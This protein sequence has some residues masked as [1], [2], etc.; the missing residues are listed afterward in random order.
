MNVLFLAPSLGLGG[1]EKQLVV[2]ADMLQ[3]DLGLRVSAACLDQ[4][5]TQRLAVLK[6]LGVPV[7]IAGTDRSIA[8]RIGQVVS[9]ARENKAQIVHAFS[10]YLA[11]LAIVTAMAV[12]ATPAASFQGDGVADLD[13]G[14]MRRV[15]GLHLVEFFTS[16]SHEAI[17]RI[18][19]HLP[20]DAFLQYVPNLVTQ[21]AVAVQR[22]ADD[23]PAIIALVVARLD[24]NKRVDVF[25]EAL[26]RARQVEPRLRGV[27]VGDGPER[28]RLES[29]A[30]QH[31]L[32]GSG[33]EFLGLLPDPSSCYAV[34][35]IFVHLARSEGT[36]NVVLEAMAAGLPVVVT[37][38]GE[39]RR[40]V[41]SG[42]NGLLVSFDDVSSVADC[43]VSLARSTELRQRLGTRAQTEVLADY[44]LR[45]V[46][47]S[48]ERFYAAVGYARYMGLS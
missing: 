27:I 35:D 22:S 20:K 4:S 7:V 2:W 26:A 29:L 24:E 9:F 5:R 15:S 40:I 18:R 34:A 38:A 12:K 28:E 21:P 45:R 6:E 13:V 32:L 47:D 1:A 25:V 43:L 23:Q 10:F 48:L 44:G 14:A 3:R 19:T 16:N 41:R 42:E 11:P 37:P 39:V 31:G 33:V 36:P 17:A 8:R 46:K 30:R